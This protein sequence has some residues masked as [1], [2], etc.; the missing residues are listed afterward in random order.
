M[1]SDP[2]VGHTHNKNI[3]AGRALNGLDID[4]W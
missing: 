4:V 1:R 3:M 2:T